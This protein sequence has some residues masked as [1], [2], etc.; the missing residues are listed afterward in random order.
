MLHE[1]NQPA[2]VDQLIYTWSAAGLNGQPGYGVRA[3]SRGLSDLQSP[4]YQKLSPYLPYEL[5]PGTHAGRLAQEEA[6]VCLAFLRGE[7]GRILLHKQYTGADALGREGVYVT[8]LLADLPRT[9]SAREAILLW[10]AHA[11]DLW[12]TA[13]DAVGP[14][15][16]E[17][18]ALTRLAE[19]QQQ[20]WHSFSLAARPP[21]LHWTL[22]LFL[23]DRPPGRVYLCGQAAQVA[24]TIW[25]ITQ[26]LPLRMLKGLTFTTYEDHVAYSRENIVGLAP[27]QGVPSLPPG[28]FY[29][30]L[31]APE[32]LPITITPSMEAYLD[33]ALRQLA[34]RAQSVS[35]PGDQ[36]TAFLTQ[37]DEQAVE[38]PAAL[39]SLFEQSQARLQLP[40]VAIES[41]PTQTLSEQ[42]PAR[43]RVC[44]RASAPASRPPATLRERL[45]R[46]WPSGRVSGLQASLL[47]N[48][49]L[50]LC[51]V[52]LLL[53]RAPAPQSAALSPTQQT[54][55]ATVLHGNDVRLALV[56]V[57]TRPDPVAPGQPLRV[58][59]VIQN[60][61]PAT[62][63]ARQG[64]YLVCVP[65]S[66]HPTD[67]DCQAIIGGT[68]QSEPGD[69]SVQMERIP[70]PGG[71]SVSP[72]SF[73]FLTFSLQA[74]P[75]R[76]SSQPEIHH[77][78]LRIGQGQHLL[79]G[80]II[81]YFTVQTA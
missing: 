10:P 20:A 52:G 27:S 15:I 73:F 25:C 29:V 37:A 4:R 30:D 36:L 70:A 43:T 81:A 11:A 50:L 28:F 44:T 41:L 49:L 67:R 80:N 65:A 77:I 16:L 33:F 57:M 47:L 24:L 72:A 51:I 17:P 46:A 12:I 5:P 13:C 7:S 54:Q 40:P 59:L 66:G 48:A 34:A 63:A 35:E 42:V 56:G 26:S 68:Q 6:P 2:T 18:V 19:L 74:Q 62:W 9:F 39:L 69:N 76:N 79:A 3:A 32:P 38:H 61:G 1:E 64:L 53:F 21:A 78:I 31:A 75:L 14:Q 8:H 58:T 55:T 22:A 23:Q 45:P 60:R 71:L